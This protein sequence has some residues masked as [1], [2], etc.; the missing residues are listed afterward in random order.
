MMHGRATPETVAAMRVELGLDRPLIEQYGRF[1]ASALVGDFGESIIQ[2]Q[3]VGGIVGERVL[4]TVFLLLYSTVLAILI[5]LPLSLIAARYSDRLIDHTIRI[6]GMRSSTDGN[7]GSASIST[8]SE[9]RD[10]LPRTNLLRGSAMASPSATRPSSA[11]TRRP[12][13]ASSPATC[14]A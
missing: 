1:V 8:R 4:P 14:S 13:M 9:G 10:H 12:A 5:A 3:G 7:A 2:K 6:G 11:R